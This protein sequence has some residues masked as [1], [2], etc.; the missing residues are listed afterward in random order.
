MPRLHRW[1]LAVAIAVIG[2]LGGALWNARRDVTNLRADLSREKVA[3]RPPATAQ[4]PSAT[5]P[6][7]VELR[8]PASA[9]G[10]PPVTTSP[11]PRKM[12]D[13]ERQLRAHLQQHRRWTTLSRKS[14]V[15]A[16]LNLPPATAA[17][18]KDLLVERDYAERD[19]ADAAAQHGLEPG[20]AAADEAATRAVADVFLRMRALLGE[21]DYQR[22]ADLSGVDLL[23]GQPAPGPAIAPM[24]GMLVDAGAPANAQQETALAEACYREISARSQRA[25]VNP[26][27]PDPASGLNP[28]QQAILSQVTG[29][30]SPVQQQALRNFFLH[31][32]QLAQLMKAVAAERR[33]D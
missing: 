1:L 25:D 18:F 23:R 16:G 17:A 28:S 8:A 10:D 30:F 12:S 3:G 27:D 20:S 7:E 21:G 2:V 32:N 5:A 29:S 19:A 31:D 33:P 13:T 6:P 11:P 14:A 15:L 9:G 24:L 22:Y 4:R 26:G